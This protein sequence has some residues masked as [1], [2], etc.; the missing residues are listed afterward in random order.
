MANE[1]LV[2]SGSSQLWTSSGGDKAITLT[3]LANNTARVGASYDR[4]ATRSR[5]I[6]VEVEVD[7]ASAPTKGTTLDVYLITSSLGTTGNWDGGVDPSDADLG[8]LDLLPQYV[9]VG[10]MVLDD[11]TNKQRATFELVLGARYIAPVVHNNGS[12]QALT[13]TG[14][15]QKVLITPLIDEVQ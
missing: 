3:S 14:T 13:S 4:G 2:K 7:F 15:D 1:V 12:G 9:F 5:R 11:T 8:S 10:A 6:Q